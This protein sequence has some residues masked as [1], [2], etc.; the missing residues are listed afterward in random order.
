[1]LRYI[2]AYL[3]KHNPICINKWTKLF[4]E[5][6]SVSISTWIRIFKLPFRT[7]RDTKLQ[8]FQY[9]SIHHIIPWNVLL[10][11]SKIKKKKNLQLL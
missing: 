10:F 9:K 2:L 1:M 5:L 8:T 7:V 3:T 4:L 6:D 11:N